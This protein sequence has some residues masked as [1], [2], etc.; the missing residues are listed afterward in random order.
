MLNFYLGL[1][2]I[3]V[4]FRGR[5][6]LW[7]AC[8]CCGPNFV[9]KTFVYSHK[10]FPPSKVFRYTASSSASILQEML[11]GSEHTRSKASLLGNSPNK[12]HKIEPFS[13][14]I[15]TILAMHVFNSVNLVLWS[16]SERTYLVLYVF[17]IQLIHNFTTVF[18]YSCA[19][20]Y[21]TILHSN[22]INPSNYD[23]L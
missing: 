4:N 17:I 16:Q 23:V 19:V 7:I 20:Q 1:Q 8:F 15:S 13:G 9:E 5:K 18:S 12:R 6:L 14:K 10:N 2:H 21:H 11:N 3:A 22:R